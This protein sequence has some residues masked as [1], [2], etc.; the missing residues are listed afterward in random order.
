M[1]WDRLPENLWPELCVEAERFLNKYDYVKQN[2]K[3]YRHS[4]RYNEIIGAEF[5]INHE[6]RLNYFMPLLSDEVLGL[7]LQY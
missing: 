4:V 3:K 5:L 7:A 6:Q 2:S 1:G